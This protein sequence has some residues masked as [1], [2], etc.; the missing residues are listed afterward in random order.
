MFDDCV[1]IYYRFS[2]R[3]FFFFHHVEPL[4]VYRCARVL[5]IPITRDSC[6]ANWILERFITID[7]SE[8]RFTK[9]RIIGNYHNSNPS[10]PK[11]VKPLPDGLYHCVENEVFN[12]SVYLLHLSAPC[13][14]GAGP[15]T[16]GHR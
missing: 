13:I 3:S 15:T 4:L 1:K 10:V 5:P 2:F 16:A 14:A 8:G 9:G 12:P 6:G 7:T 11:G